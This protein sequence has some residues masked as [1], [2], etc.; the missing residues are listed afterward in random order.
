MI[1]T[2]SMFCCGVDEIHGLQDES[3]P[4]KFVEGVAYDMEGVPAY[5]FYTGQAKYLRRGEKVAR[6]IEKNNFGKVTRISER[7]MLNEKSGNKIH[8]WVWI[9]NKKTLGPLSRRLQREAYKMNRNYW[10]W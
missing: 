7:P 4:K 1:D 9:P 6:Y 2:G 8:M 3:E 10:D 5:L